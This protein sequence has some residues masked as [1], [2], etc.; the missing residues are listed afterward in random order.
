[1]CV[2]KNASVEINLT[3]GYGILV[4]SISVSCRSGGGGG[5]RELCTDLPIYDATSDCEVAVLF[6]REAPRW[7]PGAVWFLRYYSLPAYGTLYLECRECWEGIWLAFQANVMTKQRR[8][9]IRIMVRENCLTLWSKNAVMGHL[10]CCSLG[11]G[12]H[13]TSIG[14][15]SLISQ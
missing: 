12:N 1:M 13:N 10:R 5:E 4:P 7:T 14:G 15:V 11:T 9:S 6:W 8:F 2:A 3:V